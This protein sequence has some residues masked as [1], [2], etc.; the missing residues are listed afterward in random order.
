MEFLDK[1]V[2]FIPTMSGFLHSKETLHKRSKYIS[3]SL[4]H[5]LNSLDIHWHTSIM[6]FTSQ[7]APRSEQHN[8]QGKTALFN[9]LLNLLFRYCRWCFPFIVMVS[10]WFWRF[11]FKC[12][13]AVIVQKPKSEVA[14]LS[15]NG[16]QYMW[17]SLSGGRR[18]TAADKQTESLS[19]QGQVL[20]SKG[21][22]RALAA[23]RPS[24]PPPLMADHDASS[25]HFCSIK[26]QEVGELIG[27]CFNS[28]IPIQRLFVVVSFTRTHRSTNLMLLCSEICG[29]W[30]SLVYIIFIYMCSYWLL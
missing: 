20:M 3:H 30:F 4:K 15:H 19:L 11:Y 5:E 7:T 2:H 21:R 29:H 10:F 12:K 14:A 1:T 28:F 25:P 9:F 16:S 17:L 13:A 18:S 8:N 6:M 23:G 24:L 26:S 22:H 27:D